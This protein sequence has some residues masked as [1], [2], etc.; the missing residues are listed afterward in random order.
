MLSWTLKKAPTYLLANNQIVF[1][2]DQGK[3]VEYNK[4]KKNEIKEKISC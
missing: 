4:L 3:T 2:I 1:N